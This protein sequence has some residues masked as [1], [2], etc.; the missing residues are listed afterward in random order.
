MDAKPLLALALLASAPLALPAAAAAMPCTVGAVYASYWATAAG[1]TCGA[2]AEVPGP[3]S[4]PAGAG[5]G[6]T[7]GVLGAVTNEYFHAVE[8]TF[9]TLFPGTQDCGSPV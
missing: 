8:W 3:G 9:C 6:C 5:V 1:S 7:G 2:Y 4:Q